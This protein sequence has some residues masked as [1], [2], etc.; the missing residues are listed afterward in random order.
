MLGLGTDRK[1]KCK[2]Q[3]LFFSKHDLLSE[4]KCGDKHFFQPCFISECFQFYDFN[5]EL[6]LLFLR[7]KKRGLL[8]TYCLSRREWLL[9]RLL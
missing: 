5:Y 3:G 7:G 2:M 8:S 4:G 6:S 1:S 9:T